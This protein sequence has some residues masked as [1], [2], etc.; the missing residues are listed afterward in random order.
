LYQ[1]QQ[2]H[3]LEQAMF[4]QLVVLQALRVLYRL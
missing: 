2:A 1:L 3:Q 4:Q